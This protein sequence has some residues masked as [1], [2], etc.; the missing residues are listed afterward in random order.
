[1]STLLKAMEDVRDRLV[2][3]AAGYKEEMEKFVNSNPGLKSR[4][5]TIIDFEDYSATD[6]LNIFVHEGKNAGIRLS[7]DAQIAAAKLM[8]S[9]ERG[10]KGF[11]NGRAVRNIFEECLARQGSRMRGRS[12]IDLSI[13]EAE[14]IPIPGEKDFS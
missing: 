6:L 13:F 9:L 3:I 1:M 12:K 14:D 4:F 10:R 7:Y 11:G 5:K 8:E 2:V